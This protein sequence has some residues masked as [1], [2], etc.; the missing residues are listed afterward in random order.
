MMEAADTF[1]TSINFYQTT[2]RN[3][4]EDSHFRRFTKLT[5][6]VSYCWNL[7]DMWTRIITNTG[8]RKTLESFMRRNFITRKLVF[9]VGSMQG[10]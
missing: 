2:G 4:P 5:I 3:N 9:G 1:E 6:T 10:E 7:D 8:P